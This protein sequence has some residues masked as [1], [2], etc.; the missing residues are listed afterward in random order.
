MFIVIALMLI[1][2]VLFAGAGDIRPRWLVPFFFALPLWLCLKI[3]AAGDAPAFAPRR[4]GMI[5][6]A[7]MAG[8]LL[9]LGLR[10]PVMGMLGRYERP[11]APYGPAIEAIL[12]AGKQRPSLI[13]AS[14]EQLAG[15]VRLHA[16]DMPVA[17]PGF[18][19]LQPV[20]VFDSSH[21]VLLIWRSKGE[22]V[23]AV[24]AELSAWLAS[25]PALR[26]LKPASSDIAR[27]YHYG[28]PADRYHFSYAWLYPAATAD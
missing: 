25:Q 6:I 26:G 28:R 8:V 7:F 16:K 3:E 14:D 10:T 18:E 2:L 13:V 19:H 20:Y 24:A 17:V 5:A 15:N 23:P 21:P 27:P 4:F 1:L 9:I 11:N 12:A 22:A